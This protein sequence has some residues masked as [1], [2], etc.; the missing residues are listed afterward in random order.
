MKEAGA[1]STFIVYMMHK[2]YHGQTREGNKKH[3]KYAKTRTFY[4]IKGEI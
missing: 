2:I 1:S 3:V 4:E